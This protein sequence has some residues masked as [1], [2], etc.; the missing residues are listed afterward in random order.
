MV[1]RFERYLTLFGLCGVYSCLFL[2]SDCGSTQRMLGKM[3][4]VGSLV[5]RKL[6]PS[7]MHVITKMYRNKYGG[8]RVDVRCIEGDYS[9]EE[10][11]TSEWRV[12]SR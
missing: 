8:L 11:R 7:K 6:L 10:S 4:K 12:L 5:T 2:V 9:V 3:M 1:F